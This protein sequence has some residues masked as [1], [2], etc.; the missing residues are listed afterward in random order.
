MSDTELFSI[1]TLISLIFAGLAVVQWFLQ[2]S[3]TL[4][5]TFWVTRDASV[6][7]FQSLISI[8]RLHISAKIRQLSDITDRKDWQKRD[9]DLFLMLQ[10]KILTDCFVYCG[11]NEDQIQHGVRAQQHPQQQNCNSLK[12]C[13]N[14]DQLC[15][16]LVC[17]YICLLQYFSVSFI[18]NF[19]FRE[20]EKSVK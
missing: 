20:H 13:P 8:P 14:A 9:E 11:F 17:K 4:F 19:P 7:L 2:I 15:T 10:N 3:L 16:F 18:D 6:H 12:S 1:K 5:N